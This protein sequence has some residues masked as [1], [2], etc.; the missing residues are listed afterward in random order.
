MSPVVFRPDAKYRTKSYLIVLAL[1]ALALVG[2]VFFVAV[3]A[4]DDP[5]VDGSLLLLIAV[6]ANLVWILPIMV[7]I[8]F[9]YRS[10]RYE[11]HDDEVIVN[12]GVIT[13]TVKHVPYRTVTNLK[14]MQ[15]PFDRL[16]GIGTVNIQTAGMSGQTGAEESLVGLVDFQGVY[17]QVATELRRFRGGMSP[18]GADIDPEPVLAQPVQQAQID[19]TLFPAMLEELKA[20]RKTLARLD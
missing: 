3:I 19:S 9:Y 13:K 11:I 17:D 14:V 15:G 8:P 2:C 7:G 18:T 6:L 5:D 1:G 4:N 16:F 12:V 20:I 10:L